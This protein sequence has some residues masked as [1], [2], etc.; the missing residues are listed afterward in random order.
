MRKCVCWLLALAVFQTVAS[1]A[2]LPIGFLSFDAGNRT[3]TA[4]VFDIVNLTGTNASTFPDMGFPSLTPVT[5]SNLFLTV[6][7]RAGGSSTLDSTHFVS[8]GNGG[9]TGNSLF[10][11]AAFPIANAILSGKLAPLSLNLNDGEHG[12]SILS[13]FSTTI[14]PGVGSTL[15]LGDFAIIDAV[16]APEPAS[17]LLLAT[18]LF[19]IVLFCRRHPSGRMLVPIFIT[20]AGQAGMNAQVRLNT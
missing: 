2:T 6:T 13:N 3:S 10:N 16:T 9:F 5:L 4:G 19:G 17:F 20:V 8:D 7:F 12:I 14:V 18:A 11:L 15:A 1:T